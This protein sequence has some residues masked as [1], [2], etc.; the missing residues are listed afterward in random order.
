MNTPAPTRPRRRYYVVTLTLVAML[1][2]SPTVSFWVSRSVQQGRELRQ[3]PQQPVQLPPLAP[4]RLKVVQ[5][6]QQ[7]QEVFEKQL[8][9]LQISGD[10]KLKLLAQ[11]W[12]IYL[13]AR[14]VMGPSKA[15]AMLKLLA[16]EVANQDLSAGRRSV[17]G[18][19]EGGM[20]QLVAWL[21]FLHQVQNTPPRTDQQWNTFLKENAPVRLMPQET[22]RHRI[23]IIRAARAFRFPAAILAAIVDNELAGSDSAYGLAGRLRE[24][25]D[26]VALRN[27]QLYGNSGLSGN[28]SKTVGIAQMS[29]EDSLLQK[30][31]F[32]AFGK[33]IRLFPQNESQARTQLLRPDQ[34]LL[35]TASRLRGYLNAALGFGPL[36][37]QIVTAANAYFLGG[38]WH[39]SPDK[40]QKGHMWPYAWNAFFKA[41]L[42]EFL[43]N[44]KPKS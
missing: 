2:F 9:A 14:R 43:L 24:F 36:D 31:R 39:N 15:S 16:Q 1:S 20:E 40:A 25:T 32:R 35:F 27:A 29:W 8:D 6:Y 7:H 34:N 42:Y 17:Y 37:T 23:E 21:D 4:V 5:D 26:V 22:L 12:S 30:E 33:S 18:S 13:A 11:H 38:A 41:C 28:L 3:V 19:P 44:R 10:R